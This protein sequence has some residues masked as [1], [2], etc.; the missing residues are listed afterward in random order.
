MEDKVETIYAYDGDQGLKFEA[1]EQIRV[2]ERGDNGWWRG[3]VVDD[4]SGIHGWFPASY[5]EQKETNGSQKQESISPL[6][7]GESLLPAHWKATHAGDGQ[8]YY[9]NEITQETS[10]KLPESSGSAQTPPAAYPKRHTISQCSNLRKSPLQMIKDDSLRHHDRPDARSN[11][12][13]SVRSDNGYDGSIGTSSPSSSSESVD[14]RSVGSTGS[15][16]NRRRRAKQMALELTPTRATFLNYPSIVASKEQSSLNQLEDSLCDHFWEDLGESTG[17]DIVRGHI[18]KGKI[19]CREMA[20]F[21]KERAAIEDLY[22]RNLSKLSHY[23][24]GNREKGSCGEA[25]HKLKK[26]VEEEAKSHQKLSS[27]LLQGLNKALAEFADRPTFYEK[28]DSKRTDIVIQEDRKQVA[29]RSKD[30]EK[31][32]VNLAEKQARLGQLV[33][34]QEI[35]KAQKKIIAA[36]DDLKQSIDNYNDAQ[37]QW[38]DDSILGLME[39]EKR[40]TE[41]IE[42]VS[43]KLD[44]YTEIIKTSFAT[45]TQVATNIAHQVANIDALIDRKAFMDGNRTGSIRPVDLEK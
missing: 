12:S 44:L 29:A 25:W 27:D 17:F 32:R 8:T 5:V 21:F 6:R 1:G 11:S 40:E 43:K 23:T 14:A 31:Q 38:I 28:K 2:L 18:N 42:F 15:G 39:L 36:V 4:P 19:N 10:W 24:L 37:R 22:A 9:Y 30:V 26:G 16:G 35:T 3:C 34:Q 13:L 33:K 20:E 7:L 45:N 41:R